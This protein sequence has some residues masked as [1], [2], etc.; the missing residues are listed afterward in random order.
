[1]LQY[2]SA[3]HTRSISVHCI[4]S[5]TPARIPLMVWKLQ[6]FNNC[7]WAICIIVTIGLNFVDI[8]TRKLNNSCISVITEI[9]RHYSCSVCCINFAIGLNVV[10]IQALKLNYSCISV[11][12][13][14]LW[15]YSCTVYCFNVTISLKVQDIQTL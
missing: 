8:Q 1:M 4:N 5:I 6:I 3:Y 15:L 9:F 11:I 7:I 2:S 12:T 14:T 10:D 13:A